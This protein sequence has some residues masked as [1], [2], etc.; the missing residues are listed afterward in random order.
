[1]KSELRRLKQFKY[2]PVSLLWVELRCIRRV[3]RNQFMSN[4]IVS[5]LQRGWDSRRPG[6]IVIDHFC[7]PPNTTWYRPTNKP[8]L[9]DLK[10]AAR[11]NGRTVPRAC[12]H[13]NDQRANGMRPII[14]VGSDVFSGCYGS[15]LLSSG[16]GNI[17]L[18][19]LLRGVEDWVVSIP[20]P[21]DTALPSR[22]IIRNEAR[23][24]SRARSR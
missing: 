16:S 12:R 17:A 15:D 9:T 13:P 18:H 1:M 2:K 24:I 4:N 11:G 8:S 14:P 22:G 3:N 6:V 19:C 20:S 7:L 23:G 5:W 21:L 10:P